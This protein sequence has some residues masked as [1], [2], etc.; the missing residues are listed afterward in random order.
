MGAASLWLVKSGGN[1]LGPYG[2]RQ[3]ADLLRDRVLVPLDEIS[4]PC[5]RWIYIRDEASFA[6]IVEELR[7]KNMRQ[8]VDDTTTQGSDESTGIT[9]TV[10]NPP[11]DFDELTE[12]ISKAIPQT[13]QDI[14]FQSI[15]DPH[16]ASRP[17]SADAFVFDGDRFIQK[18]AKKTAKWAWTLTMIVLL[19]AVGFVVFQKFIAEP[20][21]NRSLIE[22][23]TQSGIEALE[24]GEYSRALDLFNQAYTTMPTETSLYLYLGILKIQ[25]ENQP[26]VGRQLLEKLVQNQDKDL[27][28]VWT[29]IGL[30]QLKEEQWGA[31]ERSFEKS[32][33][34]DSM[35][36]QAVINLG[37]VALYQ[38]QWGKAVS[39]LMLARKDG[40]Q[41]GIETLMLTE[42]L[43]QQYAKEPDL[44]YL[45]DGLANIADHLR[46]S[47]GYYF[48]LRIGEAYLHYLRSQNSNYKN[49]NLTG[50][51][52]YSNIAQLLDM[53]YDEAE[54]TRQNLF[55][56]RD[57]VLWPTISQWCL[58]LTK[59]LDPSAQVIA[60]EGICLLKAGD[61]EAA[62]KKLEDALLQ[63]PK[64]PAVLAAHS[65]IMRESNSTER[66]IVSAE[67]AL[68]QSKDRR[69]A[70]PLRMAGLL[71]Q[72][73]QD[74]ECEMKVWTQLLEIDKKSLVALS[75]LARINMQTGKLTQAKQYLLMAL[76]IS[77]NYKPIIAL[78]KSISRTED[79]NQS[80]G[81]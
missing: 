58:K 78:N 8:Y 70:Q 36:D 9:S 1:I 64:D 24:M 54:N 80:R 10:T 73:R 2:D 33:D 14:L 23:K 52:T 59:D 42:A 5:G 38:Q 41:D 31:A 35:F 56:H 47:R 61:I 28:R 55:V 13:A 4:R 21:Q 72:M 43:L 19:A 18:E 63:S 49:P 50:Q 65:Y 53:D 34:I 6:K 74:V 45:E 51:E 37:A 3:V 44:K 71:C 17:Q 48:Q 62:N 7:L 79:R 12:D 46:Q 16:M 60:F 39:H 66:A 69:L 75:G 57:R 22:E 11:G 26:F 27:K 25:I 15:D 77:K 32:L 67:R 76:N 68:E 40:S 81:L 29:G 30:A 20:I